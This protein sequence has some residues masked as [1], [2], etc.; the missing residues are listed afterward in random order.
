MV[1]MEHG[2][3]ETSAKAKHKV[4]AFQ[5]PPRKQTTTKMKEVRKIKTDNYTVLSR[6]S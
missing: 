4:L 5:D 1:K 3:H 2:P 6:H